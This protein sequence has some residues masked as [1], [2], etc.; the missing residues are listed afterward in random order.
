MFTL[1]QYADSIPKVQSVI[2]IASN[3]TNNM[4][5]CAQTCNGSSFTHPTGDYITQAGVALYKIRQQITPA[6]LSSGLHV[7]ST[8]FIQ[9]FGRTK[10]FSHHGELERSNKN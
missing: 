9:T 10:V 7:S 8:Q 5:Y 6:A 4:P 1:L 3:V 2:R